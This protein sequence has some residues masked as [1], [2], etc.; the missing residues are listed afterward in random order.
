MPWRLCSP[1]AV[2]RPGLLEGA[3]PPPPLGVRMGNCGSTT[4]TRLVA[5]PHERDAPTASQDGSA[6]IGLPNLSKVPLE[7]SSSGESAVMPVTVEWTAP[8]STPMRASIKSH[9]AAATVA[10]SPPTPSNSVL[11]ECRYHGGEQDSPHAAEPG[12]PIHWA[13]RFTPIGP[14]REEHVARSKPSSTAVSPS[15]EQPAW[16]S[17][18]SPG[19]WTWLAVAVNGGAL[20]SES[21][22]QEA[23]G[24][25]RT[26]GLGREA[27]G[28]ASPP[29]QPVSR[30]IKIKKRPPLTPSRYRT[31]RHDSNTPSF[32]FTKTDAVRR[33]AEGDTESTCTRSDTTAGDIISCEVA[34]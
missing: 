16:S 30:S 14:L 4:A 15:A 2:L 33:D 3:A 11:V 21:N 22:D 10:S 25:M 27:P 5:L 34:E 26:P 24:S 6:S 28:A 18:S 29:L 9:D 13:T 31:P 12:S 7:S 23:R 32:T 1:F 8:M 19:W 20:N 17:P